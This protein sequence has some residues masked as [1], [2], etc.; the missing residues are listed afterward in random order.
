VIRPIIAFREYIFRDLVPQFANLDE[1]ATQVGKDH[2]EMMSSQPV[3]GDSD[4][5]PS[6]FAEDAQ[7]QAIGWYQMMRSL[8]Q[9]MF[10]L[11]AAGFFHLTEQ[12]LTA[13]CYDAGFGVRPPGDT[14]LDVVVEWYKSN[15]RLDLSLLPNWSLV[16]ELRVLTNT[17]KHAEGSGSRRLRTK[18][19]E[20]FCDPSVLGLFPE[21]EMRDYF[22]KKTVVAP[23]GGEDIFVTEDILKHYAEGVESFFEE[24]AAHFAAHENENY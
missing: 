7:D 17:I 11:L 5:D 22:L 18:R 15:L 24:I 19:P 2:Y 8:R 16:D 20:L 4:Y 1:R 6:E 9:T 23:L 12:Q 3:S 21:T 14:K 10:N 13:L